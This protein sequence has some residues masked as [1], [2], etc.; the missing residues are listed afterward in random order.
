MSASA[1]VDD[2]GVLFEQDCRQ[3]KLLSKLS[4]ECKQRL[5]C[6]HWMPPSDFVWPY[7]QKSKQRVYLRAN[8]IS[9]TKYGCFKLSRDL[10]GVLCVP[11]ALFAPD[12]VLNDR[13]KTTTLG[14]LVTTPLRIYRYLTGKDS[15]LD[16]HLACKYHEDS[17]FLA[18]NFLKTMKDKVDIRG[19]IDIVAN[20]NA[21]GIVRGL[22][23]S[24]KQ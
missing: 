20:E 14:Q 17:Q 6:H 21:N 12:S 16:S 4:D 1:S 8:H 24:L 18:D 3:R 9:G 10:D 23:Q 13:G 7:Y 5:L 11:C 19:R 2:I 22:F 15:A